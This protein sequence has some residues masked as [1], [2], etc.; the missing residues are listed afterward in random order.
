MSKNT[1]NNGMRNSINSI[2]DEYR[3][4][5]LIWY[6]SL[7]SALLLFDRLFKDI[8]IYYNIFDISFF[9]FNLKYNYFIN[10]GAA[11]SIFSYESFYIPKLIALISIFSLFF[12]YRLAKLRYKLKEDIK[13]EVF[14]IS[15]GFS[16]L[17]DRILY[18]GVIDY[19]N[20]NLIYDYS[21]PV[22]N[23]ADLFI[24]SGL[25]M[26]AKKWYLNYDRYINFLEDHNK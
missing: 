26:L 14:I 10:H 16:N 23:F 15:G 12:I 8:A 9:S 18:S 13:W 22:G 17:I 21:F 4:M 6:F 5:S 3:N 1:K 2:L 25:I 19:L 11:F 20:I 7:G 24:V